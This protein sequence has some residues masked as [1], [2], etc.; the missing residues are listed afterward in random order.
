MLAT[1]PFTTYQERELRIDQLG[2]CQFDSPLKNL[3]DYRQHSI[4]YVEESDRILVDNTVSA[5]SGGPETVPIRTGLEPAGAR[6][7]IYFDPSRSSAGIVT[8]G[9]LCPGLNNVV[10]ALVNELTVRYGVEKVFG[11]RNGYQGFVSSYGHPVMELTP[12]S[13]MDIHEYGGT[14]LGSSRGQQDA[15]AM[16]DC[17]ESKGIDVLFVVGGDGTIRGGMGIAD[18]IE[19]R[20]RKIAVIGIPKTI[21][22]D[23]MF[24]D[25]SFGFQTAI[26]EGTTAVRAAHVEATGAPNGVGLVKLMGRHSGFI[27]CYASLAVSDANF[28][29]IPE[30]PFSLEGESG[31]F[32]LLKQRLDRAGQA[33]IV[34]AE[35]AG[36]HLMQSLGT[37]DASGNN[38][39]GDVG[40]WL[41]HQLQDHFRDA[42]RE[43]N[44]KY[45][46]PSYVIRS[47]P[48]NAYDSV[49]CTR[50]AHNAV[51]AAMSGRTRMVVSRWHT[52]FVH[53]PMELAIR[54]RNCVDPNGDLWM[55]VLES[56]GQPPLMQ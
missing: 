27:A 13:V 41:K 50:L 45:I 26:S 6:R 24:T 43:L 34:V 20:G 52:R 18:E 16:V 42:K 22:N 37:T 15:G 12:E 40:V 31:L 55:T 10:R 25:Q 1:H 36:Q 11:F 3:L 39:L 17:I 30:V 8:C 28:V 23:I 48:A 49:F 19:R 44:L 21:D 38:H 46:D 5:N 35:G 9:G 56:T 54:S 4:N 29:L 2:E 32:A 33:V 14:I 47:V 51:H 53:V 7:R